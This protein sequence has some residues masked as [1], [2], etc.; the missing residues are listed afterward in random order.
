[1]RNLIKNINR[2][3]L[4]FAFLILPLALLASCF[5]DNTSIA[6]MT[7]LSYISPVDSVAVDSVYDI[8]QNEKVTIHPHMMQTRPE[9]GLKL[10][11]EWEVS[12]KTVSTDSVFTYT[13]TELGSFSCRLIVSNDDGSV[14]YPFIINVVTPYEEG[15]TVL[16]TKEDG[17]SCL[18]FMRMNA[19]DQTETYFYDDELFSLNNP[20]VTFS[21]N[22]VDMIHTENSLYIMCQGD[23]DHAP[24]IYNLQHK[25]LKMKNYINVTGY[26]DFKPT[27]LALPGK[28]Y[29]GNYYPV[30]CENG[31]TYDFGSENAVGRAT[32]LK[33]T[34]AQKVVMFD[35]RT[36]NYFYSIFWDTDINALCQLYTGYGPFYC[37]NTYNC[38]R[39]SVRSNPSDCNYFNGENFVTMV[40]VQVAKEQSSVQDPDVLVFTKRALG[41]I[42]NVKRTVINYAFWVYNDENETVLGITNPISL[43]GTYAPGKPLPFDTST[44]MVASKK[45]NK[46]FYANGNK[47]MSWNYVSDNLS[48]ATTLMTA[49]T[50]STCQ[51]K[52]LMLSNDHERIYVS[53]YDPEQSGKNGSLWVIKTDGGEVLERY[54]NVFYK[55]VKM[56]YKDK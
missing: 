5:S 43:C 32:K 40:P 29:P 28:P 33:Y 18:S 25:T 9:K 19:A 45:Y 13:G 48:K 34:Y 7:S 20:D 6:D 49:G 27:I 21:P 11:Y 38:P 50:T 12:G 30:V 52:A 46:L 39:D 14:F 3:I 35:S 41:P 2:G 24:A 53:F 42:T 36:S 47:L 55:P 16:S 4:H 31:K 10:S 8:Y 51:I 26:S 15:I 22:A 44:A 37:G 54:D 17:G 56:L 23:D 1:M